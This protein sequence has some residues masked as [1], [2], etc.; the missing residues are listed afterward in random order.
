[1]KALFTATAVL[2][3]GT[4][5][6]LLARPSAVAA[7]LLGNSLER[8]AEFVIARVAGAA[9]LSIAVACWLTRPDA[10]D[11]A[12]SGLVV[13]LLLYNTIVAIL[14]VGAAWSSGLAGVGVWPAVAVHAGMAAWCVPGLRGAVRLTIL[15]RI[16]RFCRFSVHARCLL[17]PMKIATVDHVP[18]FPSEVV[19]E[20]RPTRRRNRRSRD[21][22]RLGEAQGLI[23]PGAGPINRAMA[24]ASTA[25]PVDFGSTYWNPANLSGLDRNEFLLGSE[26]IIPSSHL[27]TNLPAGAIGG[28]FPQQGRYGVARSDSGVIPNLATGV[29]FRLADDSPITFGIGIFGFVGGNVNYAGNPSIPRISPNQPPRSFGFGPIYANASFLGINPMASYRV[30]DRLSIGG[31]PVITSGSISLNPAFFAPGPKNAGGVLS[32]YPPATNSRPFWGGGFQLGTLYEVNEDWNLGFSYKSPVWQERWGFNSNFPDL[33]PRRIGVQAQFPAIY[34]WG[35]AYKG[36]ER[37]L[38]DVDLRYL[39]YADAGLFGQSIQDGGLGWRS[40]FAVATGGQYAVTDRLTLRA[41]YLFNT[42]PI[43]NEGTLFNIQLPGIIQHTLSFGAS[44]RVTDDILCSLAYVH[45]FRNSIQGNVVEETGAFS[46]FDTQID[47]IV[48][49]LNVQ[50]GGKR[51]PGESGECAGTSAAAPTASGP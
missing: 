41:G 31:G 35:V 7:V 30:S 26:L 27:T 33:A 2:E 32:T 17:R 42:N 39:D 21:R 8:P 16:F 10:K 6:A 46:K 19:D 43:P 51:P 18:P 11:R 48:L 20:N 3:G 23:A 29:A 28:V 12:S 13:A 25:A 22:G 15:G 5:L 24:G 40:V 37:A 47:S 38:I 45:G 14:L 50:F 9:L 36:I 44:F 34:S 49:G 1:M 4:G